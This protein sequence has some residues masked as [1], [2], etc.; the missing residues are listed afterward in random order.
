MKNPTILAWVAITASLLTGAGIL[1]GDSE[2][3]KQKL[4]PTD[5]GIRDYA[6]RQ[7]REGRDI[8][9][10]DTFGSEAFWG[11]SLHLHQTV[12]APESLARL[13]SLGLKVDAAALPDEIVAAVKNGTVNLDDPA[14]TAALL[15]LNAVLGVKGFFGPDGKLQ[16]VGIQC[17]LCHSTVD[18]S[19]S[20]KAIP[21]GNIG[22]RLDGWP[23]SRPQRRRGHRVGPNRE[24]VRRPPERR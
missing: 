5:A 16:S 3:S 7:V 10:F 4:T 8:F 20:T 15:K 18:Q 24:T 12:A 9:R 14:T 21:P 1:A 23:E 13:L 17:A 22:N 11:G 19:F 2:D 6:A